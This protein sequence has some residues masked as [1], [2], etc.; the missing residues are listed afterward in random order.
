[1]QN[2]AALRMGQA[3]SLALA[4]TNSWTNAWTNA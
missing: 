1:M 4:R 2:F 3:G